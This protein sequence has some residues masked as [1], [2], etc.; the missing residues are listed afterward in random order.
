MGSAAALGFRPAWFWR[1]C[2]R[3]ALLAAARLYQS[4]YIWKGGDGWDR[5]FHARAIEWEHARTWSSPGSR[6]LAIHGRRARL[7]CTVPCI[8]SVCAW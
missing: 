8:A 1:G 6:Y 4:G 5:L 2:A 3:S 7:T